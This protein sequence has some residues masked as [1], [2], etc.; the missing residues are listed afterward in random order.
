[1]I[2]VP[3]FIR[4]QWSRL[5]ESDHERSLRQRREL[6]YEVTE[7]Q[8]RRTATQTFED[9]ESNGLFGRILG[10]VS[11]FIFV[12]TFIG[13]WIYCISEYGFLLGVGLGWLPSLIVAFLA[14]VLWPIAALLIAAVLLFVYLKG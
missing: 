12:A 7:E 6:G 14:A 8:L 9:E 11:A 1:M 2:W 3:R 5:R 4:Q 10:G 13:S